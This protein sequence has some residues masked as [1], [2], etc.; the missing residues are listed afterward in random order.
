VQPPV[1]FPFFWAVTK[2][3]RKLLQNELLEE[4]GRY[5]FN[6]HDLEKKI[7]DGAR[8]L[9]LCSP[10]NP[11]GRAWSEEELKKIVSLCVEHNVVLVSD[12][13]HCDL[14][15]PPFRHIPTASLSPEASLQ[16]ITCTSPSKTFNLAGLATSSVII[17]NPSW[18]E[19]FARII[20]RV[21]FNSNIFGAIASEAAYTHGEKWLDDLTG[22]LKQNH[23]CLED[24]I[25]QHRLPIMAS[26]VEATFLIWLDFRPYLSGLSPDDNLLKP[27]KTGEASALNRHLVDH[28]IALVDG[29]L[30]GPGGDGFQRLNFGCPRSMLMEGLHKLLAAL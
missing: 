24:F 6:F 21:H 10:H 17:A 5:T 18:R 7:L 12:E 16:T 19:K 29:R 25:R 4:N 14:V 15:L 13:I 22:Y 2:N 30:F 26:P 3:R 9:I 23:E 1:Y 20:D 27:G 8:M 11:V 28:G